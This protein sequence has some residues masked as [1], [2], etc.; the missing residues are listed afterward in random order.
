M[1]NVNGVQPAGAPVPVEPVG[2]AISATPASPSGGVSDVMEISLVAQLVAK[3]HEMPSAGAD[4]VARVKA[5][6]AAGTYETPEKLEIAI[7]RLLK[8]LWAG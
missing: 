7:D 6:L 2:K 1:I 8:D 5:E 3:L 4:L